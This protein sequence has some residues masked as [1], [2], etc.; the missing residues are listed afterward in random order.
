MN[1]QDNIA[2]MLAAPNELPNWL[3]TEQ[4]AKMLGLSVSALEK[5]RRDGRGPAFRRLS[6]RCV[7]YDAKIVVAWLASDTGAQ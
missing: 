2:R 6:R 5:W 1:T 7:R 4:V 3:T